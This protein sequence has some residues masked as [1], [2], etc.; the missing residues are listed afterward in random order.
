MDKKTGG[1][2]GCLIIYFYLRLQ[3]VYFPNFDF[4]V[5]VFLGSITEFTPS[6][7]NMPCLFCVSFTLTFVGVSLFLNYTL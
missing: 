6:K 5:T 7:Y 2:I 3:I 4:E 1:C